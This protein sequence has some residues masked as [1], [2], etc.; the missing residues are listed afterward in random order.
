MVFASRAKFVRRQVARRARQGVGQAPGLLRVL[1]FH[2][3][4][5]V[6]QDASLTLGELQ[7]HGFDDLARQAQ[8]LGG[9]LQVNAGQA[10]RADCFPQGRFAGPRSAGGSRSSCGLAGRDSGWRGFGR[11]TSSGAATGA[12]R[13]PTRFAAGC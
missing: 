1:V 5:Q 6:R 7:E 2:R 9:V 8:A 4:A 10:T 13:V 11:G 12:R 3:R